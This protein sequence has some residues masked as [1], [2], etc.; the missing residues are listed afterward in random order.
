MPGTRYDR[1]LD[2]H[3]VARVAPGETAEAGKGV[4]D[5]KRHAYDFR[6]DVQRQLKAYETKHVLQAACHQIGHVLGERDGNRAATPGLTRQQLESLRYVACYVSLESLRPGRRTMQELTDVV[7]W[8]STEKDASGKPVLGQLRLNCHGAGRAERGFLMGDSDLSPEQLVDAL[9]RHGLAKRKRAVQTDPLA[10]NVSH[11]LEREAVVGGVVST[12]SAASWKADSKVNA[13][14]NKKCSKGFTILRRKHHCRRCGGIFCDACSTSRMALKN[15]LT[16]TGRATGTV[17]DCRVCDDC[18]SKG[19][20]VYAFKPV[21][22]GIKG[23]TGLVQVTLAMCLAAR[24]REEFSV[25]KTGFVRNCVAQ[26]VAKHLSL[27]KVHGIRVTGSNEVVK[28]DATDGI[29]K[30][31]FGVKYPGMS[32]NTKPTSG[33]ID[34]PFEGTGFAGFI[35]TARESVSIPN[36]VLGGRESNPDIPPIVDDPTYASIQDVKIVPIHGGTAMAFGVFAEDRA[37]GRLVQ[38]AYGKWKFTSW[39]KSEVLIGTIPEL[40]RGAT[41]LSGSTTVNFSARKGPPSPPVRM[42]TIMLEARARGVTIQKDPKN[43]ARLVLSGVEERR[44][45]D[46]KVFDVS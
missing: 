1:F 10:A 39:G 35:D 7:E 45:K 2:I 29:L 36:S 20:D 22:V 34:D 15:P 30:Q 9:I 26:R 18:R 13:C 21:Q 24:T 28:W 4:G 46:H 17:Q 8:V 31:S 37:T 14:E 5:R 38:Q 32:K 25:A 11:R 41:D 6:T 19:S 43:P 27:Q 44:F 12:A 3:L 23:T 42:K 33:L 16:E 40:T